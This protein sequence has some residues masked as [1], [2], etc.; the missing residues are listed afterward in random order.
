MP[1]YNSSTCE[2]NVGIKN[3]KSKLSCYSTLCSTS[4]GRGYSEL[5]QGLQDHDLDA[6]A[7]IWPKAVT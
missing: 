7:S 1:V 4:Q 6:C 3:F 2:A 5:G